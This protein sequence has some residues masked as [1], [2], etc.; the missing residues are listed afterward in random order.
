MSV[1]LKS[2]YKEFI[3]YEEN[4]FIEDLKF[5]LL[6]E[7]SFSKHVCKKVYDNYIKPS[8]VQFSI[9][10][11]NVVF[12]NDISKPIV[13]DIWNLWYLYSFLEEKNIISIENG[14]VFLKEK[15]ILDC[16]VRPLTINQILKIVEKKLKINIKK[17]F[18]LPVFFIFSK[19]GL[20]FKWKEHFDQ[21]PISNFSAISVLER[22]MAYL[23][24]NDRIL[25]VGDDD[26]V[27]VLLALIN[28][29]I[30]ITV[31]DID[32]ELL[33]VIER[34]NELLNINIKTKL[35]DIR[36]SKKFAKKFIAFYANPPYT[37]NGVKSFMEFGINNFSKDGGISFLVIGDENIGNRFLFLQKFFSEKKLML[38]ELIPNFVMY[39][40]V[41]HSEFDIIVQRIK[42]KF[43]IKKIPILFANF[44][45]FNYI[46]WKIRKIQFK[47]TI[48][49]YL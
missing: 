12:S 31:C 41:K 16:L 39:P 10:L 4:K 24:I 19:L 13:G 2:L 35:V 25:F 45:V 28:P 9:K 42:S 17:Y 15:D 37:E 43:N 8:F 23:P 20:K 30:S 21:L 29:K 11:K 14:K 34:L 44:Y 6:E 7:I 40:Y 5:Q 47:K 27:S 32:V 3:K 1:N 18:N 48:Y 38:L 36:K 49:T 46:P 22:I 33:N 26:F